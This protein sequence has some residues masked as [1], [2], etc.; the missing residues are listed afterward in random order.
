[1][2]IADYLLYRLAK[3]WPSPMRKVNESL[4]GEPGTDSYAMNYALR[5]YNIKVNEGIA[6]SPLG[7]DVLE[8]GCGHGG[9]TCY[10]AAIA[11]RH[12]HGH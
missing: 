4:G 5:Q 7:L 12:R 9:I 2:P 8:I 10:L 3:P 6:V 1:M 11:R